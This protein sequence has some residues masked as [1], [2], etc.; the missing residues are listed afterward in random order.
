[1]VVCKFAIQITHHLGEGI[2]C[3]LFV[4][5]L[6]HLDPMVHIN[7]AWC[8]EGGKPE[9]EDGHHGEDLKYPVIFKPPNFISTIASRVLSLEPLHGIANL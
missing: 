8:V 3:Q 6:N 5:M 7:Q 9:C 2:L 4:E 1:M